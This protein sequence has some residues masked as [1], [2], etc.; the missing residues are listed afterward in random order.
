M[1]VSPLKNRNLHGDLYNWALNASYHD[2]I[3]VFD[4]SRALSNDPDIYHKVYSDP[5]VSQAIDHRAHMVAAP[6][7]RCAPFSEDPIDRAAS[8]VIEAIIR[9]IPRFTESRRKLAHGF[10]TGGRYSRFTGCFQTTRVGQD[11]VDRNWWIPSY[12]VDMDRRRFRAV[13]KRSHTGGVDI[14]W[15][16]WSFRNGG[17]WEILQNP[18]WFAKHLVA[19]SEDSL[20]YGTGIVESIH[21]YL[22]AKTIVLKEGLQGLK[23]WAQGVVVAKIQGGRD[24]KTGNP[25]IALLQQWVNELNRMQG[26]SAIAFD[27]ADEIEMLDGPSTG[28]QMVKEF[29]EYLDNS[30]RIRILGANLPTSAD[31]GGSYA[32]GKVQENSTVAL[33]VGD[34][35]LLDDTLTNDLVRLAWNLNRAPLIEMGLG[36]ARMPRF[37]TVNERMRDPKE[38]A[39][40]VRTVLEA[41]ISLKA[42]EVFE[43]IDF[44]LPGPNDE[45]IEGMIGGLNAQGAGQVDAYQQGAQGAG[46]ASNETLQ[47]DPE[48]GAAQVGSAPG[49][50]AGS[51]DVQN[52]GLNGAQVSAMMDV[53]GQ[54]AEDRLNP[55]S[56]K[57]MLKISFPM[58]SPEEIDSM[59][60][61]AARQPKPEP[62]VA[63]APAGK[64]GGNGA[65]TAAQPRD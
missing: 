16:L 64:P 39:E 57:A 10:A 33:V 5:V 36:D 7:W 58:A 9:Q 23:R 51:L 18:E 19:D 22:W 52:T 65:P 59:V 1:S 40:I 45:K 32:L 38:Q 8:N 60:D 15:E 63:P 20:G 27:S 46:D 26:E 61:A 44:S 47:L 50:Q 28:H 42:E 30:M 35:E 41:G 11:T 55:E 6:T 53:V 29:I 21:D 56:A 4:P 2:G 37:M 48:G 34:Q 54:V 62:E 17:Q 3:R 14:D 31:Q 13:A 12:M 24:A 49:A 43:R 25:N